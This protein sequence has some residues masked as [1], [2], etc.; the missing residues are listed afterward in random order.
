M[1]EHGVTVTYETIRAW[2]NKFGRDY[3][4]AFVPT[5]KAGDTWF[6]DEV[7]I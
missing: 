6:L 5:R 2:C 4:N 1:A 3:A 7:F